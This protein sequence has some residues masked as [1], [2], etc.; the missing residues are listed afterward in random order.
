MKNLKD[1]LSLLSDEDKLEIWYEVEIKYTTD[2][3]R[4]FFDSN[5]EEFKELYE[6]SIE[7]REDIFSSIAR[8]FFK[9]VSFTDDEK[10]YFYQTDY[11]LNYTK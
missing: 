2:E 4:E 11:E 7:E 1:Y 6:K 3:V 8:D 5:K 9:K 10:N